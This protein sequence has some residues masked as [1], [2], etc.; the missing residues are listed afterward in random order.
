VD[1]WIV[2]FFAQLVCWIET[3]LVDFSNLTIS[4]LGTVLAAVVGFMPSF[5]DPPDW[6]N[7]VTTDV[8]GFANWFVPLD[9]FV[10]W[11]A[12]FASIFLVWKGIEVVLRWVKA[13]S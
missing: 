12:S 2:D 8:M 3:G 10:E 7:T 1:Q 13:T 6:S 4:A 11:I 9:F 5:P